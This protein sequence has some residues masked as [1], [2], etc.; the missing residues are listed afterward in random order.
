MRPVGG[1]EGPTR[2]FLNTFSLGLYP[3]VVR[4]RAS[5]ERRIGKWPSAAVSLARMPRTG[6]PVDVELNGY[7]HRLWLLFAGNGLYS[8]EGFAPSHRT[9][10]DDGLLDVRL[11]PADRPL[12][13]RAWC[14]RR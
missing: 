14:A 13:R 3:E 11:V 6:R 12:A 9:H 7:P 10:L 4:A 2:H 5:L 1:A 8:P